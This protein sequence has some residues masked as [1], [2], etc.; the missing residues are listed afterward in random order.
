MFYY[1]VAVEIH[2]IVFIFCSGFR[3]CSYSGCC[4]GYCS[5]FGSGFYS[6]SDSGSD[7]DSGCSQKS[8]LFQIY[9]YHF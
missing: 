5:D 6:D 3:C 4:S 2:G 7:F 9:Y 1:V 8:P